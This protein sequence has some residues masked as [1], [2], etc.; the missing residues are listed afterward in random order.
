MNKDKEEVEGKKARK[1]KRNVI[2]WEGHC[3]AGVRTPGYILQKGE[4]KRGTELKC[5]LLEFGESGTLQHF[6]MHPNQGGEEIY[7]K[8]EMTCIDI[9]EHS[10]A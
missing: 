2:E 5:V 1:R 6:G 8:T 4:R 3:L 9:L 7:Q 10:C